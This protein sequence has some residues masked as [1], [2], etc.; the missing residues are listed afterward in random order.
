MKKVKG[1]TLLELMITVAIV[2][3]LGSMAYSGYRDNILRS[4]AVSGVAALS[5]FRVKL[6]QF[7]QDNRAYN[8]GSGSDGCGLASSFNTDK[9]AIT[10][11]AD[12]QTYT[13]TATS[14]NFTYKLDEANT[15]TTTAVPDGWSG[16]DSSCWVINKGGD[17]Q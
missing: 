11:T 12:E 10:C 2:G 4:E 14:N 7:F 5:S 1:F 3:I 8:N 17:C 13:L 15:K 9:F 16:K 6:E